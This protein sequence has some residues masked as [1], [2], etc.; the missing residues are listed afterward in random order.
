MSS[1]VLATVVAAGRPAAISP[2]RLGPDSAATL[3]PGLAACMTWLRRRKPASSIPLEHETSAAT[4]GSAVINETRARE[5]TTTKVR[6]A[7]SRAARR[8]EV[9]VTKVDR[10]RDGR[11]S[12]LTRSAAMAAACSRRRVHN[13]TWW[14]LLASSQAITVPHAPAPS[15]LITCPGAAYVIGTAYQLV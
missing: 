6:A 8:S 9:G 4:G 15:T 12:L 7:P 5:G 11:Y 2:A 10:G 1:S 13:R 3:T 14:P